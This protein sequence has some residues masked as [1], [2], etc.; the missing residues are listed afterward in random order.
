MEHGARGTVGLIVHKAQDFI[1]H[2]Q[3]VFLIAEEILVGK[4]VVFFPGKYGIG[5]KALHDIRPVD[6]LFVASPSPGIK[7]A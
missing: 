3:T 2:R 4:R 1:Q 5:R 7:A 6:Q